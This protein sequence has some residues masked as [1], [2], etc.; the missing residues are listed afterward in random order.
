MLTGR[1]D[2]SGYMPVAATSG[3]SNVPIQQTV[4]GSPRWRYLRGLCQSR[5]PYMELLDERSGTS[6]PW[7][8]RGACAPIS[9][10][11]TL[12]Y[13]LVT[14]ALENTS[15]EP[16]S[17]WISLGANLWVWQPRVLTDVGTADA[18]R[19][20]SQSGMEPVPEDR[21]QLAIIL[22]SQLAEVRWITE[23]SPTGATATTAPRLWAHH[24]D[25]LSAVAMPVALAFGRP[26][27][28]GS[29]SPTQLELLGP[30]TVDIAQVLPPPTLGEVGLIALNE[31]HPAP[32]PGGA[33]EL[34]ELQSQIDAEL[35]DLARPAGWHAYSDLLAMC[36]DQSMYRTKVQAL[37]T[38]ALAAS[39]RQKQHIERQLRELQSARVE[40]ENL[41]AAASRAAAYPARWQERIESL[42]THLQQLASLYWRAWQIT[43]VATVVSSKV[44]VHAQPIFPSEGHRVA[45]PSALP[46]EAVLA[47]YSNVQSG[48]GRWGTENEAPEFSYSKDEATSTVQLRPES[49]Q[50]ERDDA[51][52]HP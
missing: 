36:F 5:K 3:S 27:N 37:T 34:V 40:C 33:G 44:P 17:R 28:S 39:G 30:E 20:L 22:L 8:K 1:N 21:P 4:I 38:S 51:V 46:V 6:S 43:G 25:I 45:V 49:G 48:A 7:Q 23:P 50:L 10:M 18:I 29:E 32:L 47:A 35:T 26:A 41:R 9:E 42:H 11:N 15:S 2:N 19:S 14:E 12:L 13:R 31:W 24:A 52:I 16:Q